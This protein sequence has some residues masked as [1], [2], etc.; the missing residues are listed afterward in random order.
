MDLCPEEDGPTDEIEEKYRA[1]TAQD[2]YFEGYD[3]LDKGT[4]AGTLRAPPC[5]AIY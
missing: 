2:Y 1:K 5:P 4:I 3:K